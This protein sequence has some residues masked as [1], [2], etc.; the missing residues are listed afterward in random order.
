MFIDALRAAYPDVVVIPSSELDL[1]SPGL[2][3]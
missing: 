3:M 1:N 2:G